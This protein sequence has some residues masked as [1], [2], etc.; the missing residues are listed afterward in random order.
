[1]HSPLG[2]FPLRY[3]V[4]VRDQSGMQIPLVFWCSLVESDCGI[5]DGKCRNQPRPPHEDTLAKV[6]YVLI[7]TRDHDA[8]P[9]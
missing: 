7:G 6:N 1:M 2:P 9:G 4:G 5:V 3:M 8:W